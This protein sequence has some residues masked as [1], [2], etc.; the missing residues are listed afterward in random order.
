MQIF[1]KHILGGGG[2]EGGGDKERQPYPK[3]QVYY[4]KNQN[5]NTIAHAASL[6]DKNRLVFGHTLATV[7]GRSNKS[8]NKSARVISLISSFFFFGKKND[9]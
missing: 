4:N 9:Y 3:T 1:Q 6:Q 8:L 5:G 7:S 2:D